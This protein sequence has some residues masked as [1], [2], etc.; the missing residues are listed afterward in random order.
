[1]VVHQGFQFSDNSRNPLCGYLYIWVI[2][3]ICN[4]ERKEGRKETRIF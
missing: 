2:D 1:M 3:Y 4:G